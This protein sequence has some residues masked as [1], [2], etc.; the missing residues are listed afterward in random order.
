MKTH[1]INFFKSLLVTWETEYLQ[2]VYQ[3][4][5]RTYPQNLKTLHAVVLFG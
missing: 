5:T 1:I 4:Y 2:S 3:L